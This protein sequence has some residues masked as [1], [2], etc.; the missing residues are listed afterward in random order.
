MDLFQFSL[1]LIKN[2]QS[3]KG[4]DIWW[5]WRNALTDECYQMFRR[6]LS[7]PFHIYVDYSLQEQSWSKK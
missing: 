4:E 3:L 5:V 6:P 7:Y 2:L 1:I